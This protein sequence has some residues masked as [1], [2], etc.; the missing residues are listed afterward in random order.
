M[1]LLKGQH[2]GSGPDPGYGPGSAPG[3]GLSSGC[4]VTC[5]RKV[6]KMRQI[7]HHQNKKSSKQNKT[8]NWNQDSRP[9][10]ASV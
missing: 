6:I 1:L 8:H 5:W 4:W 3:P 2:P 10:R 7:N 9:R